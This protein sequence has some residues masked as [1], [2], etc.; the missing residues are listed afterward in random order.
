VKGIEMTVIEKLKSKSLELRKERS[1]VAPS[2]VFAISEIEKVGK[3]DGNRATTDDEAIRVVQ[4]IITTI[5]ENLKHADTG[6]RIHLNYEKQILES[7]LPKMASDQDITDFLRELF[8][9][10][11]GDKIPKKGDVMKALRDHFGAL[12]DM[13]HA[14]QIAK[15][16]YGV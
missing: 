10:K 5:D 16:L 6:R 12:V 4:K 8:T 3:N 7:V 15:E 2:I 11:R 9:G 13:K 1:P 14:G